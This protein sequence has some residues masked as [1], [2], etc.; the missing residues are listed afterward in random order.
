MKS[1]VWALDGMGGG[2][3]VTRCGG[4]LFEFAVG[5]HH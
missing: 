5:W 2:V 1:I 4:R 3:V